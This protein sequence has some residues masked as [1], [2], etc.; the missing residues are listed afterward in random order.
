MREIYR[1]SGKK[2][3]QTI[4][5][6]VD[7]FPIHSKNNI[8][9]ESNIGIDY[10]EEQQE[11]KIFYDIISA[12]GTFAE[13]GELSAIL[14]LCELNLNINGIVIFVVPKSKTHDIEFSTNTDCY[15]YTEKYIKNT[16]KENTTLKILDI[17]HQNV[18]NDDNHQMILIAKR[19]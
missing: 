14:K 12:I 7:R 9:L 18:I 2:I 5:W 11:N 8:S 16:I 15:Y 17:I 4:F 3:R 1:H 10:V 6:E 19:I 13:F